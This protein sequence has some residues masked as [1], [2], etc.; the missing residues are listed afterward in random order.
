MKIQTTTSVGLTNRSALTF[1]D[2]AVIDFFS[3]LKTPFILFDDSNCKV[4]Q[5]PL[6]RVWML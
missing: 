6:K 2:H 3:R 1:P 4:S 5:V